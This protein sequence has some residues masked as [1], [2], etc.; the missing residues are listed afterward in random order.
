MTLFY[1]ICSILVGLILIFFASFTLVKTQFKKKL[2][3]ILT[4]VHAALFIGFGILGFFLVDTEYESITILAMLAFTIT[5][6]IIMLTLYKKE[7]KNNKN[8]KKIEE[9][10]TED[11]DTSKE[12]EDSKENEKSAE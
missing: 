6:L 12:N 4:Y 8:E 3:S 9:N 11:L 7:T 2:F 10:K 5:Y 1:N